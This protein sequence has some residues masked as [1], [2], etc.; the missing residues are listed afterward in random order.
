MEIMTIIAKYHIALLSGLYTTIKLSL[1]IR[2]CGIVFWL[3][4]AIIRHKFK[5]LNSVIK[6]FNII[7]WSI[8]VLVLLYRIYFPL[9]NM[10]KID[11]PW[12][13]IALLSM[14]LINTIMTWQIIFDGLI[15][16][17]KEYKI[18][19]ML[20]WLNK[21]QILRKIEI[22]LVLRHVIWPILIVQITMLHS[23]IFASLI[24]VD[25]IFRQIQR[26]NAL[27]YKPIELYSLLVVFFLIISIPMYIYANHL[28]EKYAWIYS[29]RI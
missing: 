3:L 11:I 12:F 14:W 23:T 26:I 7:T 9:Q 13:W 19:A 4:L 18:S 24:N 27:T 5:W 22:P 1:W 2:V 10:L 6:W 8:P 16:L 15:N 25:E 20:C 21:N 17:P 28:K 29:S